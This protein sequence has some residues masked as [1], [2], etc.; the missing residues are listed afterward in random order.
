MDSAWRPEKRQDS[1]VSGCQ[2]V[3]NTSVENTFQQPQDSQA[4]CVPVLL[5]AMLITLWLQS[6]VDLLISLCEKKQKRERFLKKWWTIPLF[7][8]DIVVLLEQRCCKKS[9]ETDKNCS[10]KTDEN[11]IILWSCWFKIQ[12]I[13]SLEKLL[14]YF[15]IEYVAYLIVVTELYADALSCGIAQLRLLFLGYFSLRARYALGPNQQSWNDS[16][17]Q[18]VLRKSCISFQFYAFIV[19]YLNLMDGDKQGVD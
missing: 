5:N 7:G 2:N 9:A 15:L 12:I 6:G 3:C 4:N 14:F 11:T 19:L 16:G 10:C 18:V 17:V 13:F 8:N 1:H